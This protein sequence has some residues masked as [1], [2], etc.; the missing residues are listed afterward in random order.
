ML[1]LKIIIL[2]HSISL[3]K[4]AWSNIAVKNTFEILRFNLNYKF[5]YVGLILGVI[6]ITG[7][8]LILF[9]ENIGNKLIF[10]GYLIFLV[11]SCVVMIMIFF[12]KEWFAL[13]YN[14]IML[15]FC[16]NVLKISYKNEID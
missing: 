11:Y 5:Y 15:F 16:F 12:M 3:I 7:I 6:L 2:L 13:F 9:D 1:L 14:S 4:I 10:M 8:I